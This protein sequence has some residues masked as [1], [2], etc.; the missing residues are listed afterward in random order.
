MLAFIINF[1]LEV[2]NKSFLKGNVLKLE[3]INN[4]KYDVLPERFSVTKG[5]NYS[6]LHDK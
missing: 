1:N 4:G 2:N 6:G 3:D 5:V